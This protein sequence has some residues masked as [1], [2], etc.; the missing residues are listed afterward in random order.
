M[1]LWA[2]KDWAMLALLILIVVSGFAIAPLLPDK[3]PVHWNINGEVDGWGSKYINLFLSS[4]LALFIYLLMSFIP[5][6]DPLRKNYENFAKPYQ[7]LKF[8]LTLFFIY[9]HVFLVYSSLRETP[10]QGNL[11]FIIPFSLLF[12]MIGWLLPKFK[13]NFFAGIRTPWTLVSDKNWEKTHNFGGKA[14]IAAGILSFISAFFGGA[15][16]FIVLISS[17]LVASGATVVYS[18]LEYRKEKK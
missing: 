10:P 18:Y 4:G 12:I 15:A 2:K 16:S 14:F 6:I 5:A 17:I 1:K 3:V 7:Y 11:I 8:F 13:R 9:L